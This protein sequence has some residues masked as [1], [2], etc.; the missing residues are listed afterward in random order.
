MLAAPV[1]MV[2]L[3][4]VTPNTGEAD[5][6]KINKKKTETNKKST[7]CK[8]KNKK[9]GKSQNKKGKSH[10]KR[11]NSPNMYRYSHTLR[12]EQQGHKEEH[13]SLPAE[14]KGR[15]STERWSQWQV[16]GQTLKRSKAPVK[17]HNRQGKDWRPNMK[18]WMKHGGEG[19][20][21]QIA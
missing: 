6:I 9:R 15:A 11:G 5:H 21:L 2:G 19:Q 4:K 7:R 12:K 20:T 17:A 3:R 8:K 16:Q 13:T 1:E 14:Q 10:H 18:K